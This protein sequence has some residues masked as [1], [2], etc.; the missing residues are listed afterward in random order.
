MKSAVTVTLR[1]RSSGV[2]G[3][4]TSD[5]REGILVSAGT[6]SPSGAG[7]ANERAN[8]A[9]RTNRVERTDAEALA[10][11]ERRLSARAWACTRPRE[12]GLPLV[13]SK[14]VAQ[15]IL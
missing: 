6:K 11:P 8:R 13:T 4:T 3:L 1:R 10:M 12:A 14:A 15:R 9:E 5:G 7:G 2:S